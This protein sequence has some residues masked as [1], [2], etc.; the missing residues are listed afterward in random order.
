MARKGSGIAFCI[1]E[2]N[3]NMFNKKMKL[4][5]DFAGPYENNN[6]QVGWAFAYFT[7]YF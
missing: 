7:A 4:L 6:H 3:F 5:V 2:N 1:N